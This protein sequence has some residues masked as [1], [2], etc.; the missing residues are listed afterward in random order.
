MKAE[1]GRGEKGEGKK[2]EDER[3]G[4]GERREGGRGEGGR[5]KEDDGGGGNMVREQA[6]GHVYHM[7]LPLYHLTPAQPIQEDYEE[8]EQWLGGLSA[9]K[10]HPY[11]DKIVATDLKPC[12]SFRNTQVDMM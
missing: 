1:G 3:G 8:F 10:T 6:G 12:L 9:D 7:T 4:R 5:K 11:L 2:R